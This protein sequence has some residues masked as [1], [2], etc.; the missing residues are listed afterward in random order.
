MKNQH[1]IVTKEDF[2]FLMECYFSEHISAF[3]KEILSNELKNAKIVMKE[4]LPGNVVSANSIVL[5][6]NIDK[7]QTFNIR[8]ISIEDSTEK[9]SDIQISDPLAVALLG[10]QTGDIAEWEMRD[11]INRF[12]IVSVHQADAVMAV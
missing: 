9:P 3:N 5:V 2:A 6:C 10:Y 7:S 11:G 4:Y 12:Q 1:L 8:I